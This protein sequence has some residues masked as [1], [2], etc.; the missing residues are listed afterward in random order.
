[1]RSKRPLRQAVLIMIPLIVFSFINVVGAADRSV[2]KV[3]DDGTITTKVKAKII[4]NDR[5]NDSKIDVDTYNGHVTLT[6]SAGSRDDR[7][8]AAKLA[9]SVDG[10]R[11]VN[12]KLKVKG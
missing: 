9:K 7:E 3:I 12:N 5:L 1:M 10:V 4:D 8:R 6:G 2:G 11:D